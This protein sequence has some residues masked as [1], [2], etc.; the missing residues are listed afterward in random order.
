MSRIL[1]KEILILLM[2]R[3][4][5]VRKRFP[6]VVYLDGQELPRPIGFE[7]DDDNTSS[8][9][10]VLNSYF[11]VPGVRELV[12]KFIEQYYQIYDT[13]DR[14]PLAAAYT[15]DAS[16]SLSCTFPESGPGARYTSIYTSESRNLKRISGSD[17][18]YRN[19]IK[20]R[21]NITS[22]L[23]RLPYT[24]HDP[25]S[26]T[27]D[28]PLA[29]A[30]LIHITLTGVFRQLA[31]RSPLI[32]SFSRTFFVVPQGSGYCICNE[33]L[34]ITTATVEQIKKSF[35]NPAPGTPEQGA[36]TSQAQVQT[37]T[38]EQ[39]AL[40]LKFCV[41]SAMLPHFSRMCLEQNNWDFIKAGEMFTQLK[42]ENKIPPEYFAQS[43]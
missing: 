9:P 41:A 13:Q 25:N 40:V 36:S 23:C 10:K 24:T 27:V 29:E 26:F 4:S 12:L 42:A 43:P 20:G 1:I 32:R 37:L 17:R 21:D 34:F 30:N 2:C 22:L 39:E 11:A 14:Q 6:K 16:F 5:E 3:C 33:E 8:M 35:K 28:V 15:E 31:D 38:P 18:R 7:V 19:L